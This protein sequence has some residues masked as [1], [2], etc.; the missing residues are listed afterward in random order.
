MPEPVTIAIWAA[1]CA[2]VNTINIVKVWISELTE[3]VREVRESRE[4][5]RQ[6]E[7]ECRIFQAGF[8][9]WA[10]MWGIDQTVSK[11]YLFALWGGT[12]RSITQQIELIRDVHQE[13]EQTF[14][15]FRG[16]GAAQTSRLWKSVTFVTSKGPE[17]IRKLASTQSQLAAVKKLS[18]DAFHGCNGIQVSGDILQKS[19]RDQTQRKVLCQLVYE[20]RLASRELYEICY[21]ARGDFR[22]SNLD[23]EIDIFRQSHDL[24]IPAGREDALPLRYQFLL[25]LMSKLHELSVE[26]PF[27]SEGDL[28]PEQYAGVAAD[29]YQ[30]CLATARMSQSYEL[31]KASSIANAKWFRLYKPPESRCIVEAR[32]SQSFSQ[33]GHLRSL[34]SLLY[35]LRVAIDDEPSDRFPRSER[36]QFAFKLAE[37][38]LFLSGTSWLVDLGSSNIRSARDSEHDRHFLLETTA[39]QEGYNDGHLGQFAA[40]VFAVGILLVEVGIGRH[41]GNISR[42][43]NTEGYIF[44]FYQAGIDP[45]PNLPE[46]ESTVLEKLSFHMGD[47]YVKAVKTCLESRESWRQARELKADQLPDKYETMLTEYYTEVYLP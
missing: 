28:A 26:G 47:N 42:R 11:R 39:F 12:S 31:L 30:A 43:S 16:E 24:A 7:N 41:I 33:G 27:R 2:T 15:K 23:L 5:M 4:T 40:H 37:C 13:V 45:A 22:S 38:G 9:L 44:R 25:T 35:D 20:S 18:K 29:F 46:P 32:S 6:M 21:R 14:Q 8:E 10:K 36:L 34:V 17:I 1:T 19:E 3:F